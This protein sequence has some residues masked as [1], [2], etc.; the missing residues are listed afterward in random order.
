VRVDLDW[1]E[2]Q[3]ESHWQ[4]VITAEQ[5]TEMRLD[6]H[7]L[8]SLPLS[9]QRHLLRKASAQICE[10]QSP[11]EPRHQIAIEQQL[12]LAANS[13][14]ERELHLPHHL[15][16]LFQAGELIFRRQVPSTHKAELPTCTGEVELSIP[17]EALLPG[18]PWKVTAEIIQDEGNT[19][20]EALRQENWEQVWHLLEPPTPH[21]VYIDGTAVGEKLRV[22]TRRPGDR[23]QPLG[24]KAEKKVQ[25]IFVDNHIGRAV[26]AITPLFF[27]DARCLWVAGACLDHRARL[28]SQTRRILRLSI[29]YTEE[30]R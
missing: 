2:T 12:A 5:S 25:D 22:R 16:A 30:R 18:T 23:I 3:V 4:S 28:T 14:Q 8:L 21:A 7:A 19:L 6:I 15:L 27:S 26:R 13:L 20:S 9:L 24:M 17:G 11:L 1:L 10:G 29:T